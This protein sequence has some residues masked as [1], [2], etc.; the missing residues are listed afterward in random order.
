MTR[1]TQH[2]TSSGYPKVMSNNH[3]MSY[4]KITSDGYLLDILKNHKIFYPLTSNSSFL[5]DIPNFHTIS[6]PK[7]MLHGYQILYIIL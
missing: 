7:M 1:P 4:P 3:I 2:S 5:L 6:Y